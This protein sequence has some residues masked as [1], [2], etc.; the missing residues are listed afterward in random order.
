[1]HADLAAFLFV[2]NGRDMDS[3]LGPELQLCL[4]AAPGYNYMTDDGRRWL[5]GGKAD[6][7]YMI[8]NIHLIKMNSYIVF[9]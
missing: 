9:L 5:N 2:P 7:V 6:G 3:A 1:M 8:N 4:S